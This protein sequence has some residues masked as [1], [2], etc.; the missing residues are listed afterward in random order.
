MLIYSKINRF[1]STFSGYEKHTRQEKTVDFEGKHQ[2][3]GE[4]AY[5]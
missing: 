1:E 3:L 5:F 2:Q 4:K